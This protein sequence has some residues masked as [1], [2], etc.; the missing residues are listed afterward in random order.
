MMATPG[1]FTRMAPYRWALEPALGVIILIGWGSAALSLDDR[2]P[3]LVVSVLAVAVGLA[4]LVPT[5][6]LI[7]GA[8]ATIAGLGS[9]VGDLG[10]LALLFLCGCLITWTACL[11]GRP[12]VRFLS[13]GAAL[14][15][16]ALLTGV[17]LVQSGGYQNALVALGL[18]LLAGFLLTVVLVT[19]WVGAMVLRG[20]AE[21]RHAEGHQ[22]PLAELTAELTAETWLMLP[23]PDAWL[24]APVGLAGRPGFRS[25]DRRALLLD[26]GIAGGLFFISLVS[27]PD[28]GFLSQVVAV[29]L[30]AALA[31]RRLSPALALTVAWISA[32]T[33]ILGGLPVLAIDVAILVVLYATAAYGDRV[34]RWAGLASVGV[35]ALLATGHL[36]VVL[37]GVSSFTGAVALNGLGNLVVSLVGT[38]IA[39]LAVLG[40]SWTLGL[41]VRT[42]QTARAG[43]LSQHRASLD[44]KAAERT[45]VVEQERTRIARDMHDVV[46]HSLAV[47][48]AQ[49]DGARYAR[50]ANPEAADAALTIISAT[51]REALGD[52]RILLTRLRQDDAAGPQPVLA[53]LDRL[54]EQMRSTGLNI[55]WTT[56]GSATTVGT[57]A[58]LAVYRIVQEALTNALRHGDA[59]LA[60]RLNLAWTDGWVAVTIDNAVRTTDVADHPGEIGHGLPGMR[61]RAILAGGSLT[62]EALDG[63]FVVAGR[64]PTITTTAPPGLGVVTAG[65]PA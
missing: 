64:L 14:L 13:L 29:G 52:V 32:V 10:T 12:V 26:L 44:Q 54:V 35:G 15:I 19:G 39:C 46:A 1:F 56:T 16:G 59:G 63:R 49:A 33:Q 38:F 18:A 36:T 53:D 47:V 27:T 34:V 43:R 20:R 42:W 17:L 62:A 24:A 40:M 50:A 65:A 55:E 5:G 6:A 61:E 21:R 60:V 48:I 51:A 9:F 2:P 28:G 3:L 23:P 41:L 45:V 22:L 58:Q 57:G 25:L 8:L 7:G 30:G 37:R 11:G 4:R 31:V